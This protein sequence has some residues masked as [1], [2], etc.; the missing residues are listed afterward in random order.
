MSEWLLFFLFLFLRLVIKK[1]KRKKV[2]L[3]PDRRSVCRHRAAAPDS[4]RD[5]SLLRRRSSG[6]EEFKHFG[7][8]SWDVR[9]L[10]ST[11]FADSNTPHIQHINQSV[12]YFSPKSHRTWLY[13]IHTYFSPILST[14]S[15]KIKQDFLSQH[16]YQLTLLNGIIAFQGF[17]LNTDIRLQ[18]L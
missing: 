16:T 18:S 13:S 5:G 1:K 9:R 15:C 6:C 12:L 2:L 4:Q 14:G 10:F 17:I 7:I 3:D 8:H 11:I